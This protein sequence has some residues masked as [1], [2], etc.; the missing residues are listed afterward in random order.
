MNESFGLQFLDLHPFVSQTVLDR[1]RGTIFGGALGD[2]IGLYSGKWAIHE[3]EISLTSHRVLTQ[4]PE[5]CGISGQEISISR[6][7]D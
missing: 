2:A 4:G 6:T 1:A 3:R 7:G 5:P